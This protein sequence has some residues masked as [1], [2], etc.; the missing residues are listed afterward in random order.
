MA[1]NS[2]E[3]T[4][5]LGLQA[6]LDRDLRI[7]V[8]ATLPTGLNTCTLTMRT[9]VNDGEVERWDKLPRSLGAIAA[10]LNGNGKLPLG[11]L[12][13]LGIPSNATAAYLKPATGNG[14]LRIRTTMDNALM[15]QGGN[16]FSGKLADGATHSVALGTLSD[17]LGSNPGL[18]IAGRSFTVTGNA[19]LD[20][21]VLPKSLL[22]ALVAETEDIDKLWNHL[23]T[24]GFLKVDAQPDRG[25]LKAAALSGTE[26]SIRQLLVDAEID[27]LSLY[28]LKTGNNADKTARRNGLKLALTQLI[29]DV[30]RVRIVGLTVIDNNAQKVAYLGAGLPVSAAYQYQPGNF[31]CTPSVLDGKTAPAWEHP[32]S[33]LFN[34]NV[35]ADAQKDIKGDTPITADY[36][37]TIDINNTIGQWEDWEASL[38]M[39]VNPAGDTDG[40]AAY[41]TDANCLKEL[42]PSETGL[43]IEAWIKPVLPLLPSGTVVHYRYGDKNYSM[44]IERDSADVGRFKCV[45]MFSGRKWVSSESFPIAGIGGVRVPQWRHLAVSHKRYWGYRLRP[46]EVINCGNDNSLNINGEASLEA[47][48]KADA[49]GP[50]L[51]KRGEY[52]LSIKSDGVLSFTIGGREV[53]GGSPLKLSLGKFYKVTVIRSL[54]K[55]KAQATKSEY[56]ITGADTAAPGGVTQAKWYDGKSN[57]QLIKGMAE[58]QDQMETSMN[59]SMGGMLGGAGSLNRTSAG[60]EINSSHYYSVIVTGEDNVSR[61]WTSP[62]PQNVSTLEAYSEFVMGGGTFSGTFA[63]VRAWR[64]AL[65]MEEAKGIPVADDKTGLLS[66]WRMAEGKGN[67]LYDEVGENHGVAGGGSWTDSPQPNLPG[68]FVLCLDGAPI[69]CGA[70]QELNPLPGTDNQFSIGGIKTAVGFQGHF[71]GILEEVRVWGVPRTIEEF[72]DN[73]FGRLKGEWELL[74]ANYTFDKPLDLAQNTV[75]DSGMNNVHLTVWK[76]EKLKLI[77]STAPISTEIPQVRSALTGVITEYNGTLYSRPGV[78]EYGDVQKNEDG[79]LK[80]ILKRCYSF[81]GADQTW[82]RMTGYKVGNL[83]SHWFGQVQFDPQVMGFIEGA[84]PVPAE[85]LLAEGSLPKN[86][87]TLRQAEQVSYNYN[88]S[89]D[90]GWNVGVEHATSMEIGTEGILAPFGFGISFE[91]KGSALAESSWKTSG[92]RSQSFERGTSVETQRSLTANLTGRPT[93]IAG[94][95]LETMLGNTGY[96]LVKSKTADIYLLRLAHNNALISISWQPNPDIPEDVNVIPFPINP[97]YVKQGSLDGK[98]SD[99]TDAHYPQAMGAYGQYS[100]FK[101]REAYALKNRIEREQ[102]ELKAY[103]EDSFDVAKTNEHFQAAATTTGLIQ[104][105][106]AFAGPASAFFTSIFNQSFG[107]IATQVGYNNTKLKDDL[108]RMGSQRNLVNTYAWTIEGGFYAESTEVAETQQETYANTT[109]LEMGGKLGFGLEMVVGSGFEHKSLFSSGSSFALTKTKTKSSSKSFGLD[110]KLSLPTSPRYRYAGVDRRTLTG[111]LIKPGTV[112]AYRFMSFYLEP[113]AQNFFDLFTQVIDPIWLEE[114]ADPSAIALRQ[115]RGKSELARPCWRV[116]HRVTFVSRVLPQFQ[117]EAPPS[118]EKSMQVSGIESNYMLIKRFEPYIANLAD[119]NAFFTKIEEIIN[120]QLPELIPHK[121]QVKS[122]LALYYNIDQP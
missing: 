32:R 108:A 20:S 38:A 66:L 114:S 18:E 72:T 30:A 95:R 17:F 52:Q 27:G 37:Y 43:S 28:W 11:T 97:L 1:A 79:T 121:K 96:A 84:P 88:T 115:A 102:L 92:N 107:Q 80:G 40:T 16:T 44:G 68:Q 106:G 109:T 22:S 19:V 112:D 120:G 69:R 7:K 76:P 35:N 42:Q 25:R 113:K 55:P 6:R 65:S 46:N 111:G 56:P 51:E 54:Q 12:E 57:D 41:S 70:P 15:F 49:A 47:L 94:D 101:P 93:T 26:S 73:A 75:Q 71:R 48:V 63:G 104:S 77:L 81:I 90:A 110:V 119:S 3:A 62:S 117:P 10:I 8:V 31:T 103:F 39:E 85:N 64:R 118:L 29:M 9:V 14:I 36:N 83:V 105:L 122:Y 98:V 74:L 53:L 2:Q 82:N 58:K 23:V 89:K 61:E 87:V 100:Y 99:K 91:L 86:S 5:P 34:A 13:P 50:I 33:F 59:L 4:P 60:L 45:A 24:K 67:Y 116:M 78:V 21:D